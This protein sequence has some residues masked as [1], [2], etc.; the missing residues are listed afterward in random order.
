MPEYGIKDE[1]YMTVLFPPDMMKKG[2]GSEIIIQVLTSM[3]HRLGS[4]D[5]AKVAFARAMVRAVKK[6]HPNAMVECFIPPFRREDG[7]YS[8]PPGQAVPED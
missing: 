7:F 2:L 3:F 4:S 1:R 8:S 5:E 6:F